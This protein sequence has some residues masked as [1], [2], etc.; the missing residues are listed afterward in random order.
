[1]CGIMIN[2]ICIYMYYCICI[3]VFMFLFVLLFI[4]LIKYVHARYAH[5]DMC[6]QAHA[7]RGVFTSS[8]LTEYLL[9]TTIAFKSI[10]TYLE[11][12]IIGRVRGR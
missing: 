12:I 1:M 8:V 9:D 6:T 4:Y 11:S 3:I 10:K 2:T 5:I 7:R